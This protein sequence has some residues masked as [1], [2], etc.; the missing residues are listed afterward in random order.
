MNKQNFRIIDVKKQK[1]INKKI[2]KNL[3]KEKIIIFR[4]LFKKNEI[5][6]E[7]EFF[8]KR[9]CYITKK[10]GDYFVWKKNFSRIDRRNKNSSVYPRFQYFHALFTWNKDK[11]FKKI[12]KKAINFRNKLYNIKNYK[13]FIF[14]YKNTNYFDL[15][16]INH[17]PNRGY[18]GSHIDLSKKQERNFVIVLSEIN[19]DFSKG[20]YFIKIKNKIVNIEKELQIGDMICNDVNTLHGVEKIICKKNQI[21]KYSLVLSMR[22]ALE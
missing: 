2:F 15:P 13:N 3:K 11:S 6:K 5:I 22:K 16:K 10:S 1:N 21:G 8:T 4:N 7:L 19:K 9:N 12:I 17:Y 18:L 20:G 14:K